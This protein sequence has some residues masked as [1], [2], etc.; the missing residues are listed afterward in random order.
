MSKKDELW[1]NPWSKGYQAERDEEEKERLKRAYDQV[2]M[3]LNKA[4]LCKTVW[5]KEAVAKMFAS[6]AEDATK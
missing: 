3:E 2:M 4:G 1:S 5:V 6:S